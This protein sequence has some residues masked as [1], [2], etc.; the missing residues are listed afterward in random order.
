M[1]KKPNLRD[2]SHSKKN[3]TASNSR[4]KLGLK[5]TSDDYRSKSNE[6]NS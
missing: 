4:V 2:T 5:S 6:N 1:L 3:K